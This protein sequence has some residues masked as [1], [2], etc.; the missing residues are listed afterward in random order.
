MTFLIAIRKKTGLFRRSFS[1]KV[2]VVAYVSR[3]QTLRV[4]A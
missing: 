1:Q 4:P 2:G 3:I